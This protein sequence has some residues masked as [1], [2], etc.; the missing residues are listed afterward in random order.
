MTAATPRH[1]DSTQQHQ[2][3]DSR[4]VYADE[5]T[6][7]AAGGLDTA[8]QHRIGYATSEKSYWILS[9]PS[10]TP[11]TWIS[12]G[13]E[14]VPGVTGPASST[15]NAIA[16]WNGTAGDAIQ[17]S[18][19]LINDDGSV[20]HVVADAV[21]AA[22]TTNVTVGHNSSGTP[23][24]G[25]GVGIAAEAET[26][27]TADTAI[28]VMEWIWRTV[29]HASRRAAV[30]LYAYLTT[31]KI[32][33]ANFEAP[34]SAPT[35]PNARGAGSVDLQSARSNAANVA[36]GELS[37]VG[38]GENN[39]ATGIHDVV[40]G[41][42]GNQATGSVSVVGGGGSNV[43]SGLTSAIGGG[44]GNVASATSSTVAGGDN[45]DATGVVSG[46]PGG[47]EATADKYGQ[48]ASAAGGFAAS[49]DAQGTIQMVA[50]RQ[51]THSDANWYELFLDGSS[52][53]I[54]LANNTLVTFDVLIAGATA[55][56]AKTFNY[57]IVGAIE[58]DGGI[59]A[60]LGVP[61][62]TTVSET[63][64]T[65]D[66]RATADDT[67]DALLIEVSDSSAQGDVVRWVATIRTVELV[68]T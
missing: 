44:V 36:S 66:A 18:T 10:P 14:G 17:N 39:R 26:D 6:L 8:L 19:S 61:V 55:G 35:A 33:V 9:N 64:V 30:A 65:F 5:A 1:I 34:Q 41:G 13:Q 45:N 25:F 51:V 37:V 29:T 42:T 16:R 31:N 32:Q 22:V 48:I 7:L 49:G 60:I 12:L 24:A 56:L 50:R 15:D 62:V 38:G 58:N 28:G 53:R 47:E 57:R 3:H 4:L 2:L 27:T 40:S 43:A 11:A 20:D 21:T 46:I 54:T 23:A 63:D 59:T 52:I 68:Y 67:N